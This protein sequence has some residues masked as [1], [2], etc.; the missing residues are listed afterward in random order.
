M[1]TKQIL[2]AAV[3]APIVT[4]KTVNA[5][6]ESL[7]DQVGDRT[8][9]ITANANE[10]IDEWADEGRQ[11]VSKVSEGKVVDEIAA[12]VDFDQAREQV[13]KLRD[14]LE[15]MLATWRSSFRPVDEAIEKVDV[16]ADEAEKAIDEAEEKVTSKTTPSAKTAAKKTQ[17]AS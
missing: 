10:H 6:F 7:R 2:Y 15:D 8:E 11:V 4:L 14:Q 1:D 9:T 3:G 13:T 12:K 16:A 5:R 17:K